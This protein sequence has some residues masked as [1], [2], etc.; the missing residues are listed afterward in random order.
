MCAEEG[1][2][3]VFTPKT[4]LVM[5]TLGVLSTARLVVRIHTNLVRK[6]GDSMLKLQHISSSALKLSFW[7]VDF[8]NSLS[9][10]SLPLTQTELNLCSYY[11]LALLL[12]QFFHKKKRKIVSTDFTEEVIHMPNMTSAQY[13]KKIEEYLSNHLDNFVIHRL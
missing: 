13:A 3:S 2:R 12:V 5:T 1:F 4:S 8:S 11:I 7:P 6:V 9:E 10:D